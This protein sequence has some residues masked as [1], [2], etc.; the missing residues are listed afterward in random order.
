MQEQ[1]PL[2]EKEKKEKKREYLRFLGV[3]STVGI[4]IVVS[5]FI[6]FALGYWVIDE[7]LD[8]R[9]W[10]TIILTLLGIVAGF[11]HMFRIAQKAGERDYEE[12]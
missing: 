1:K 7:Y 9:P 4:N 2:N 8:T 6:G 11:R 10:F 3:A 12:K 5:T